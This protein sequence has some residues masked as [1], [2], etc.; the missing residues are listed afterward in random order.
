MRVLLGE[1]EE[2][3]TRD[4]FAC[5]D[6]GPLDVPLRGELIDHRVSNPQALAASLSPSSIEPEGGNG[7]GVTTVVCSASTTSTSD[8]VV[9]QLPK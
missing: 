4:T 9:F 2:C 3:L 6:G 5:L 1:V 7:F 8:A